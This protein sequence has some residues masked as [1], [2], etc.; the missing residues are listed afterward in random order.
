VLN[1]PADMSNQVIKDYQAELQQ[2][3]AKAEAEAKAAKAAAD[4]G[5]D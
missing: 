4:K 5:G 3:N 2:V 1:D